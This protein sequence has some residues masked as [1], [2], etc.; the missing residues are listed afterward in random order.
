MKKFFTSYVLSV[1][2][3]LAGLVC[4]IQASNSSLT[5]AADEINS[6]SMSSSRLLIG[7][8]VVL[9]VLG[10]VSIVFRFMSKDK[11]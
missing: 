10:F 8:G 2:L 9:F 1:P 11:R 3:L 6:G 5:V 4:L 7:T